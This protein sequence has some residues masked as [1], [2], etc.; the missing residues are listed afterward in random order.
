M[1]DL[2]CFYADIGRPY[3]PLIERMTSSARAVMPDA[4]LTVITP[5]PTYSLTRCFDDVIHY[6]K[7]VTAENLMMEVVRAEVSWA[8]KTDTPTAFVD[9]DLEF[10]RPIKFGGYDIGLLWRDDL[11][12]Q[13]VNAGLI[14]TQ[15]GQDK[16]WRTFG[17]IAANLP[18]AMRQWW[19]EQLALNLMVGIGHEA[20]D[21]F[22]VRGSTVELLSAVDHCAPPET[23]SPSAWA[24]HLKGQRK[25][26]GW[27]RYFPDKFNKRVGAPAHA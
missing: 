9:V 21:V 8:V 19:C 22:D 20:G 23:A 13:P 14:L 7:L 1:L 4:R 26:E 18:G 6:P 3:M 5:T 11:P 10:K 25:G 24:H 2:V 12:G 16:F 17:D 27:D 15:P